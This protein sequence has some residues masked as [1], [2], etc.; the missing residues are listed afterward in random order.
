MGDSI[1]IVTEL[2]SNKNKIMSQTQFYPKVR[3]TSRDRCFDCVFLLHF[4][5]LSASSLFQNT[6]EGNVGFFNPDKLYY[7]I[8]VLV[9]ICFLTF[10]SYFVYDIPGSLPNPLAAVRNLQIYPALPVF[11]GYIYGPIE[12]IKTNNIITLKR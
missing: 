4:L 7:R 2:F 9:G 3:F 5:A 12:T 6:M 11:S 1:S 8:F 10:G